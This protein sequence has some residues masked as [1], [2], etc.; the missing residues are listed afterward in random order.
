LVEEFGDT[1]DVDLKPDQYQCTPLWTIL[2]NEPVPTENVR[3][4]SQPTVRLYRVFDVR[5]T[6]SDLVKTLLSNCHSSSD[7]ELGELARE[8]RAGWANAMLVL[9]LEPLMSFFHAL[10][11]EQR[12]L[13]VMYEGFHLGSN[14]TALLDGVLASK[15]Q[16]M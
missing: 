2:E 4:K 13:P 7:R 8:D 16:C 1:L 15:Y 11:D 10:P 12:N 5:I 14:V 6:D 3:A 9:P